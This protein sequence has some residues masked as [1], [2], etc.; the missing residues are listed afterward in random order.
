ME[1]EA[2]IPQI[3]KQYC[4]TPTGVIIDCPYFVSPECP[5]TCGYAKRIKAGISHRAKTGLER[6]LRRYPDYKVGALELK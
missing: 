6:F 5:N 4:N 2:M 1:K 3:Y